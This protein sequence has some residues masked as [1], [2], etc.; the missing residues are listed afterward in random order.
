MNGKGFIERISWK[1][2]LS[3]IITGLGVYFIL[4]DY[5]LDIRPKIESSIGTAYLC[6]I[7]GSICGAITVILVLKAFSRLSEGEKPDTEVGLKEID[8]EPEFVQ[9]I[10]QRF[11]R[12]GEIFQQVVETGGGLS[13]FSS[14]RAEVTPEE[15]AEFK[16]NID[17]LAENYPTIAGD[18][19]RAVR[20]EYIAPVRGVHVRDY[21]PILQMINQSSLTSI[22]SGTG[23]RV[24]RFHEQW[25]SG[26]AR[27][28]AY[29]GLIT[30]ER[31]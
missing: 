15:E 30:R 10:I 11:E 3:A 31:T 26:R 20:A 24:R 17:W 9:Q 28:R 5:V 19:R 4:P 23:L 7:E 12:I 8:V 16:E 22:V 14:L 2:I 21:D 25:Q 13:H 29:L 6:F 27:L 18:T 1:A